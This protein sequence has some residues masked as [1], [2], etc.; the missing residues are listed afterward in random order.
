MPGIVGV[1]TSFKSHDVAIY[2]ARHVQMKE[3][4]MIFLTTL[5]LQ[6]DSGG[7]MMSKQEKKWV[8]S[9]IVSWG[10]G[11]ARPELPGVYSRVSR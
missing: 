2:F 6:G 10:F 7:P 3:Y 11:C 1:Q 9:G 8:Q 5:C 4:I